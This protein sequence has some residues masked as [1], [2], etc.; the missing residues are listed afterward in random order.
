MTQNQYEILSVEA[1]PQTNHILKLAGKDFK[2]SIKYINRL[3]G[4]GGPKYMD[5]LGIS[6]EKYQL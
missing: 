4:R 3:T 1:E 6:S 2:I 5:T